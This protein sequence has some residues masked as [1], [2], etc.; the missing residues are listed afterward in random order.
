MTDAFVCVFGE[1]ISAGSYWQTHLITGCETGLAGAHRA[2]HSWTNLYVS[3]IYKNK[4]MWTNLQLRQ[5]SCSETYT[6]HQHQFLSADVSK[7]TK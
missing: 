4:Y 5:K 1:T 2:G 7:T 3:V 6:K